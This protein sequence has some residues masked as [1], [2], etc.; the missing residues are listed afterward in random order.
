MSKLNWN[1]KNANFLSLLVVL[2]G[3]FIVF[4]PLIVIVPTFLGVEVTKAAIFP[5]NL[6]F[7]QLSGAVERKFL[8]AF[9]NCTLVAIAV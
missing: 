7:S 9:T 4:L 5:S 1:L 8:L 3:V 2:T 6:D